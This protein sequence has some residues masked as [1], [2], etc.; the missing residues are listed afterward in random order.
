MFQLGEV[1]VETKR[2]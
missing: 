1:I 2:S